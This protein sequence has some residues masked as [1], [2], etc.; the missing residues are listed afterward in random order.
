MYFFS[1]YTNT[2]QKYIC[3]HPYTLLTRNGKNKTINRNVKRT[4]GSTEQGEGDK[5]EGTISRQA[6]RSRKYFEQIRIRIRT[7]KGS[8]LCSKRSKA[9]SKGIGQVK[10]IRFTLSSTLSFILQF[11]MYVDLFD[12]CPSYSMYCLKELLHTKFYKYRSI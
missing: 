4:T 11:I 2:L 7:C 8:I 12:S 1:L 3:K 6:F 5:A 9:Y 10:Q